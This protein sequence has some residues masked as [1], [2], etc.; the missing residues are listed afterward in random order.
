MLI[1]SWNEWWENTEIEPGQRF[2]DSYLGAT[3]DWA[4]RFRIAGGPELP[5]SR[6]ER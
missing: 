2:G 6:H 5:E 1:T 3:R 4:T